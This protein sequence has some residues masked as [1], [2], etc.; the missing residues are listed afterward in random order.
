MPRRGHL[1]SLKGALS[2]VSCSLPIRREKKRI[3]L[4]LW[5]GE[6]Q[7]ALILHEGQEYLLRITRNGKLILTK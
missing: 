1:G 2:P 3:D 7:E 5:L 4:A 6:D